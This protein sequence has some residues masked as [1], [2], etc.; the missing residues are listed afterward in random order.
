MLGGTIKT[1]SWHDASKEALAHGDNSA[2]HPLN[3]SG[4]LMVHLAK[5]INCAWPSGEFNQTLLTNLRRR[6]CQMNIFEPNN[7]NA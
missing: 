4:S 1:V 2:I 7:A 6:C 5:N 3:K